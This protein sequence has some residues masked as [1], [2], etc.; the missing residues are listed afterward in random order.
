MSAAVAVDARA[1]HRANVFLA[2]VLHA[3]G[4]AHQVRIRNL[5][6]IGALVD[7]KELPGEGDMVRVQRGPHSA[8]ARVIWRK[9]GTCGIRFSSPVPAQQWMSYGAGHKGQQRV[10]EIIASV[11][12]G[13]AAGA[14]AALASARREAGAADAAEQ[15]DA[16]AEVLLALAAELAGI[17]AVVDQGLETLQKLDI[18]RQK[19]SDLAEAMRSGG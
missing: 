7:G 13:E 4:S 2:A 6:P 9:A 15:I 5:S 14:A 19:L 10:D 17:P 1:C 3:G 12:S 11:R 18:A 8:A 16:V